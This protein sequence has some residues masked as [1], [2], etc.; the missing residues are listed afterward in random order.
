MRLLEKQ[1]GSHYIPLYSFDQDKGS[2][3]SSNQFSLF[4]S[5]TVQHIDHLH[6]I[7]IRMLILLYRRTVLKILHRLLFC[8]KKFHEL[9]HGPRYTPRPV[10]PDY[11]QK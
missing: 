3:R 9:F 2:H 5:T 11:L 1:R 8:L 6:T 7:L 4:V 10:P